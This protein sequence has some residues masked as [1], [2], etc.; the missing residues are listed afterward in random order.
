MFTYSCNIAHYQVIAQ[1]YG[2]HVLGSPLALPVATSSLPGLLQLGLVPHDNGDCKSAESNLLVGSECVAKWMEDKV[3]YRARVDKVEGKFLEV[4]F[5]D[6]G[7]KE[8]V[9][10]CD[11]V[12]TA[13]DI[14]KGEDID[15]FVIDVE[16][17][18]PEVDTKQCVGLDIGDVI[19]AKWAEDNVWYNGEIT[20]FNEDE[21]NTVEVCFTDY[22]D[23][24]DVEMV[25]IVKTIKEIPTQDEVD[26]NVLVTEESSKDALVRDASGIEDLIMTIKTE[27]DETVGTIRPG[28]KCWVPEVGSIV[29]A[30]WLEDEVWYN[31]K[32][33]KI[34]DEGYTVVFIDYGNSTIVKSEHI[35]KSALD[36]P[37]VDCIDECVDITLGDTNSSGLN[38]SN[39]WSEG[40][41]CIAQWSEDNVWY[42]A[43]VKSDL[44]NGL[45][46]VSFTDYGNNAT[47]AG[48]KIV[49]TASNIPPD[50]IEM[51]DECVNNNQIIEKELEEH[52]QKPSVIV[53]N[54]SLK[55]NA[56]GDY[57]N[58]TTGIPIQTTTA[59]TNA[60][61]D[62]ESVHSTTSSA[63][64][65]ACSKCYACWSEDNVWY[66]A[67]IEKEEAPG[68]YFVT[69]TDYG[70]Q[71]T[72][73]ADRI[74]FKVDD[75]PVDQRDMVDENVEFE[76]SEIS[77]EQV[78]QGND[79]AGVI[80]PEKPRSPLSCMQSGK[81]EAAVV[82]VEGWTSKV[83][84]V[85]KAD[86][87]V[88]SSR[89]TEAQKYL[90]W[91]VKRERDKGLK[92]RSENVWSRCQMMEEKFLIHKLKELLERKEDL[93][94][95]LSG[96]I[97]N[98]LTNFKRTPLVFSRNVNG[99]ETVVVVG[100]GGMYCT[101]RGGSELASTVKLIRRAVFEWI[102]KFV[103]KCSDLGV[104]AVVNDW[105]KSNAVEQSGREFYDEMLLRNDDLFVEFKTESL[106]E[107]VHEC[108]LDAVGEDAMGGPVFV[109]LRLKKKGRAG[110]QKEE[111]WKKKR[112]QKLIKILKEIRS[113]CLLEDNFIVS[114][115]S[116]FDEKSWPKNM[117]VV[118]ARL[119]DSL[120]VWPFISYD[121]EGNGIWSQLGFYSPVGW[122]CLVFGPG[123]FPVEAMEV[124]ESPKSVVVGKNI[125]GDLVWI[126]GSREGWRAIDL[127]VWTRDC[128]YHGHGENGLKRM[129][130]HTV[131]FKKIDLK[132]NPEQRQK[133]GY[134][135][136]GTF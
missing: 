53:D 136:S 40:C 115:L 33:E 118:M 37:E 1:L 110:V 79:S 78:V 72:G 134:I 36:I 55:P 27:V 119:W 64:P 22:G 122:E 69:S 12:K 99:K 88:S 77:E 128:P 102:T 93:D 61:V 25:N 24:A 91:S 114:R 107:Q 89:I 97:Q 100:T 60:P 81:P 17:G 104:E 70:N 7:N 51:I 49:I 9:A 62:K 124:L 29:V 23:T 125:H 85:I 43:V 83:R 45:Y 3:W 95:T 74:V 96:K 133:L 101:Q 20:K 32:V 30:K 103:A 46:E 106:P 92:E 94:Q 71:E 67:L 52:E 2:Q 26:E 87:V 18:A 126:L 113:T 11:V 31:A 82:G 84:E 120:R 90:D 19:I 4:T 75:I 8:S 73:A 121:G 39:R 15:E 13:M 47:V 41:V 35:L 129:F 57:D 5:L 14:P 111:L 63:I 116:V 98:I 105:K 50:Q 80:A 16:S 28:V 54:D 44:G 109:W 127:G 34:T 76:T 131:G 6:Y 58:A 68:V 123:F 108:F 132:R 117:E 48:D 42:N 59:D 86:N 135:R 66:N 112:G 10:K 38:T 21:G 65:S 130:E 56:T